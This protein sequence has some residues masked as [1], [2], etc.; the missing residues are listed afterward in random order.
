[1]NFDAPVADDSALR[2]FKFWY[3]GDGTPSTWTDFPV[4]TANTKLQRTFN[5][6]ITDVNPTFTLR[7][8]DIF[9]KGFSDT[10][11]DLC[12]FLMHIF[13]TKKVPKK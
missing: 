10:F 5:V 1:M 2:D 12:T 13:L 8:R 4:G 3:D 11:H 6:P 9:E 7:V